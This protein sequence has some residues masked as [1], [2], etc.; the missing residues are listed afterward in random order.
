MEGS[1]GK[2]I[3]GDLRRRHAARVVEVPVPRFNGRLVLHCRTLDPRMRLEM[4]VAASQDGERIDVD[5]LIAGATT[6]LLGSCEKSSTTMDGVVHDLPPLGMA[7][8]QLLGPEAECGSAQSDQEA[9]IEVFGDEADL[10]E[11]ANTL[12]EESEVAGDEIVKETVG[13]SGAGTA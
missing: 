9:A 7:L 12:R 10:V 3:A 11:A 5:G 13:N 1:L 4:S 2:Y 8:S 6:A